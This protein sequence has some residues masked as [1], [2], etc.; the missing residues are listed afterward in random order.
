MA[1]KNTFVALLQVCPGTNDIFL[2][3]SLL[4]FP[5]VDIL[6]GGK[7]WPM[8]TPGSREAGKIMGAQMHLKQTVHSSMIG[9]KRKR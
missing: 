7:P 2:C 1:M 5:S 4:L 8:C 3:P 9:D 6:C